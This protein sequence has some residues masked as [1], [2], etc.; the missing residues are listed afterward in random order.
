M[1]FK[2]VAPEYPYWLDKAVTFEDP[3]G[4]RV[5]LCNTQGVWA[6]R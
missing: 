3:D 1:G 6:P 4:R 2:A 5:V